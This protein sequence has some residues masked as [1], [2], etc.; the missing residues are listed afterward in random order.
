[1]IATP[2]NSQ[3][4]RIE[5]DV[6]VGKEREPVAEHLTLFT[7]NRVYDFTL[8]GPKEITM[9][10]TEGGKI[11]LLDIEKQTMAKV[12]TEFILKFTHDIQERAEKSKNGLLDFDVRFDEAAK[13]LELR[14]KPITYSAEGMDAEQPKATTRYREFAD[15]FARLNS[16]RIGNPPPFGRLRLNRELVER[17]LI[18]QVIRRKLITNKLLGKTEQAHSKHAVNWQLTNT[19]RRRIQEVAGHIG[20]FET[21]SWREYLGLDKATIDRIAAGVPAR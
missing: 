11:V 2:G 20:T 9:L 1:M 17:Q 15:W 21:V 8:R 3:E 4:F 12:P 13:T 7:P 14:G 19:D 5:T 16:M 6:F 18:P 10:D